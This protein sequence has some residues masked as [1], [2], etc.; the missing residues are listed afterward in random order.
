MRHGGDAAN[1]E[2]MGAFFHA[3]DVQRAHD[4]IRQSGAGIVQDP[5]G[6]DISC[7]CVLADDSRKIR[8]LRPF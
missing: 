1:D 3:A 8:Y 2:H 6:Q 7:L 5:E 4:G